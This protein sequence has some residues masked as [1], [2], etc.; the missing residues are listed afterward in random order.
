MIDLPEMWPHQAFAVQTVP[1]KFSE[2]HRR[3]LLTSPTGGGKSRIMC[4][5]IVWATQQG[6]PS[7]LYTNRKLLREQTSKVLHAHGIEHGV[8]AAGHAADLER[9]V[10]VSS[11]QTEERRVYKQAVWPLHEAKFVIIDEAH[12]QKG[13]VAKKVIQD[14]LKTGAFVLLVTATPL[15]MEGMADVLVQAGTM[16]ELRACGSLVPAYYYGPDEPDSRFIGKTKAGEVQLDDKLKTIW[17]QNIFGRVV[18]EY[19]RLNPDRKPTMTFAPGVPESIWLAEQFTKAGIRTAH[20]DGMKCWLDGEFVTGKEARDDILDMLRRGEIANVSNRFVLRE[21]IDI[22]EIEHIIVA[23]VFGSLQTNI[24]SLGRGLRACKATGKKQCI[25]QDHGGNW[26][27]HGSVNV[28]RKWELGQS[29]Y[30]TQEMRKERLREKQEQEPITCPKCHAVRL[31][32]PVCPK[33]GYEATRKSRMIVQVD[34]T[35]KERAGD[36]YKPRVVTMRSDTEQKWKQCY[37]RCRKAGMT[38]RQAEGL[39]FYE[40]HYYPP[41]DLPFMPKREIDFFAKVKDIPTTRL[42][43]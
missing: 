2:G 31:G 14:H 23:T 28:D 8:R 25:I 6:W 11:I 12:I 24:Q 17:L 16:S 42:T 38:F 33:C 40:N 7:I 39:F 21:G 34:G 1:E 10:Q 5:L 26:W 9:L 15:D 27:R 18:D 41:R 32:G 35:L 36:I 13:R 19:T 22:P 20:I 30:V 29:D 4:E 37:W 3:V 43:S